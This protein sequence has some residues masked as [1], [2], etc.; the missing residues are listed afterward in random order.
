[1]LLNASLSQTW[2]LSYRAQM[3][4]SKITHEHFHITPAMISIDGI[5]SS[6]L[7][8]EINNEL[9]NEKNLKNN[10]ERILE[11]LFKN[12]IHLQSHSDNIN[13]INKSITTLKVP[14]TPLIVEFNSNTVT[15]S[16]LNKEE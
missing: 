11:F 12:G 13:N 2:I 4:K 5:K 7:E 8:L 16:I 3:Q 10:K 14:P 6:S 1:V 15:I 9:S